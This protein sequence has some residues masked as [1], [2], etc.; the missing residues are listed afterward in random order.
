MISVVIFSDIC[1]WVCH[2]NPN[3]VRFFGEYI[4]ALEVEPFIIP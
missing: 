3:V 4:S 1:V 2:S